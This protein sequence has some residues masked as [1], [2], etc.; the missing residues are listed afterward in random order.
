[1]T[2]ENI[3]RLCGQIKKGNLVKTACLAVGISYST[4]YAW[5]EQG[6]KD[7]EARKRGRYVEF[8][9][10]LEHAE[11]VGEQRLVANV[12][13][14]GGWK[15]SLEI[16]KRRYRPEWGDKTALTKSDGSDFPANPLAGS[17]VPSVNLTINTTA[18]LDD[19]P[20]TGVGTGKDA[21]AHAPGEDDA[22]APSPHSPQPPQEPNK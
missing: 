19:N 9:E 4:F 12:L 22:P 6:E 17:G 21:P 3:S 8:L 18:P 1:M 15:G 5:K 14:K 11:A 7:R 2:P 10:E 20:F 13:T 16:L